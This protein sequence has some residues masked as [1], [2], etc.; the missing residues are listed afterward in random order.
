MAGCQTPNLQCSAYERGSQAFIFTGATTAQTQTGKAGTGQRQSLRDR[1]I[2]RTRATAVRRS[3][4]GRRLR[5]CVRRNISHRTTWLS[6]RSELLRDSTVH[7]FRWADWDY[8]HW[9]HR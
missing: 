5:R 8:V 9:R 1:S 7:A 2:R 6:G 3:D 4:A